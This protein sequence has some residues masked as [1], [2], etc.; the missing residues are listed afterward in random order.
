MY[1]LSLCVVIST[2][3]WIVPLNVV[4]V[5]LCCVFL[6]ELEL[7]P[8]D[9]GLTPTLSLYDERTI[10]TKDT[11]THQAH[12]PHARQSRPLSCADK[13]EIRETFKIMETGPSYWMGLLH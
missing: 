7:L 10:D 5:L 11:Y 4:H 9:L 12:K 3:L 13:Q 6:A 2:S 1:Y 8:T